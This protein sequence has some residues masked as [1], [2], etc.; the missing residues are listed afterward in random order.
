MRNGKDFKMAVVGGSV[1]SGH[2]LKEDDHKYGPGNMHAIL[3]KHL[4]DTFKPTKSEFIN[5]GQPAQ[6]ERNVVEHTLGSRKVETGMAAIVFAADIAFTHS[7][8]AKQSKRMANT[9][10]LQAPSTFVCV[11]TSTS[12]KTPT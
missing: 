4:Q 12:R 9:T 5:G 8:Q 1:S 10:S 6:G 2:G 3:Y 7:V 11:H